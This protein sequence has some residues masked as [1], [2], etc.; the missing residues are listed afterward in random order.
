MKVKVS[1]KCQKGKKGKGSVIHMINLF[2]ATGHVHYAKCSR[3]QLQQMLEL[4]T[5]YPLVYSMF[6]DVYHTVR[7]IDKYWAG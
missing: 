3:L 1:V 2:A 4:E 6:N 5:Q 7:R